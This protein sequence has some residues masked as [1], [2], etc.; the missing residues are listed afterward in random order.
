[1]HRQLH[2]RVLGDGNDPLKEIFEVVPALFRRDL[3]ILVDLAFDL[4]QIKAVGQGAA[5]RHDLEIGPRP[6]RKHEVVAEHRDAQLSHLL[7]ES[8]DLSDVL[9]PAVVAPDDALEGEIAFD[10]RGLEAEFRGP[11]FDFHQSLDRLKAIVDRVSRNKIGHAD[12]G[13]PLE[14][15]IGGRSQGDGDPHDWVSGERLGFRYL[16]GVQEKE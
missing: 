3:F 16:I 4:F 6:I 1:M 9:V 11:A 14:E 13:G 12:L 5:P 7:D 15:K 10:H 2:A 8:G